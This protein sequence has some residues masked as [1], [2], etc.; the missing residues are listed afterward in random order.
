MKYIEHQF[1]SYLYFNFPLNFEQNSDEWEDLAGEVDD[2]DKTSGSDEDIAEAADSLISD[3]EDNATDNDDDVA[4]NT[5]VI[6][7]S[8]DDSDIDLQLSSLTLNDKHSSPVNHFELLNNVFQLMKKLRLIIKFM[9]NHT[10]TNEYIKELKALQPNVVNESG[11]LALDMLIRWNSSFLLLD[12]L[13][14]HRVLNCVFAF[15]NNMD[16]LTDAQLQRLKELTLNQYEW[17]LIQTLRNILEPFLDATTALSGQSYPTI[18]LA[19][20]VFRLLQHF[21]DFTTRDDA[22]TIAL[23]ESLRFWFNIPCKAKLPPHQ[24]E[25]MTV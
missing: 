23:K 12:R 21:L 2:I 17:Q 24:M 14:I 13:I 7:E 11:D 3:E 8:E 25:I 6:N 9:R 1:K 18:G 20:Y 22:V 19:F 15:P 16:G 5:T 4:V 10:I